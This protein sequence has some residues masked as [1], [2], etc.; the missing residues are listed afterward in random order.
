[1]TFELRLNKF[2]PQYRN[3][4]GRVINMFGMVFPALNRPDRKFRLDHTTRA[5]YAKSWQPYT[6]W[7]P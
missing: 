4:K 3:G 1:M 7:S 2:R 6:L 5:R